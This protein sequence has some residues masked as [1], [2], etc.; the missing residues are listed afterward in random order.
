[1]SIIDV[2]AVLAKTFGEAVVGVILPIP[3]G[4]RRHVFFVDDSS[5]ARKKIAE[6][7]DKLGVKHT[8]A[9]NGMEAW[10]RLQSMANCAEVR[11][12]APDAVFGQGK[13]PRWSTL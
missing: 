12:A 10:E 9:N 3:D 2:E 7:L 13:R 8:H 6:V 11:R 1:M 4:H 5:V